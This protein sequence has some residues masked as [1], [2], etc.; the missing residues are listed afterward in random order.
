MLKLLWR[1]VCFFAKLEKYPNIFNQMAII[2][3]ET[4]PVASVMAF[5]VGMVLAL[6][7]GTELQKYGTQNIIG[8]IVGLSMVRS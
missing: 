2:N 8:A 4:L 5:F 7:T 1:T 6:Q 3:F